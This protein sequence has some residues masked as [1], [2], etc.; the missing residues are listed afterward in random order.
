MNK[1]NSWLLT[2]NSRKYWLLDTVVAILFFALL[3]MFAV[4]LASAQV[5]TFVVVRYD[6]NGAYYYYGVTGYQS[7]V[8]VAVQAGSGVASCVSLYQSNG[9]FMAAGFMQGTNPNDQTWV[10]TPHYFVDRVLHGTYHYW[11]FE[12]TN[13]GENHAY[14]VF[15]GNGQ[16]TYLTAEIDS[17]IKINEN[18]YL[19][20]SNAACGQ[21]ETHNQN[22]G[23]NHHLWAMSARQ[24][25]PIY[26]A[27][28]NDWQRVD[29]P[30][31]ITINSASDWIAHR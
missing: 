17:T 29:A 23:M 9:D 3:T 18:G 24:V 20:S 15:G 1:Y 2:R 4:P 16:S 26:H 11:L 5:P 31:Q 13:I 27:F 6:F 12:Q 19:T 28:S 14:W 21:T 10:A 25:E 8:S 7:T 22:D 30:F